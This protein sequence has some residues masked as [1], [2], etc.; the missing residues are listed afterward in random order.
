MLKGTAASPGYAIGKALVLRNEAIKI[1]KETVANVEEEKERFSSALKKSKEEIIKIREKAL[2]NLGE[3]KAAIFDAHLMILEDPELIKTI[4]Q[5][6]E[7]NYNATF[8]LK[9][10]AD[11]FIA[12]FEGM[13]NE[14][15]KERAADIRDVT[16]RILRNLT[17]QK[18]TDLSLL[19]EEVII[20]AHDLT[21]SETATMDKDKI[22]GFITNIGGRTSHTAIM[23]RTLEIPAVVGLNNATS[24]IND[25]DFIIL[26]GE[27][28]KIDINPSQDQIEEY[29]RLKD[30][31]EKERKDLEAMR[32]KASI[33]KDGRQVELGGNIGTPE[34]IN[35]LLRNDAE[36]VGLFRTE[37]LYM[38]RNTMPTEEEQFSAYKK[39]LEA[40]NPK[41]VVIRTLDIGGDKNLPYLKIDEEMNPFLGYRAI[42]LCLK[43]NKI[44]K[45]QLRAMLRASIYGNL[46]IMFPMISNLKE[47]LEAKKVLQEVMEELNQ[48]GIRFSDD[49]EVG[50]M[51]EVPSAAIISDM[52]AKHVDFFSI[53]TNDL[54]QYTCAVD[55]MNEKIHDLYQPFHPAVLRLIQMVIENG[56]KEGIWVGMCGESAGDQR[57]IPI[58][59]GMGLDEF[60]MSPISILPAR[61][62]IS[63]LSYEEWK[64]H[65]ENMLSLSTSE[66][67][68]EYV[69]R[70]KLNA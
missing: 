17:G 44:F 7:N 33:T 52:L 27:T 3:S 61:K 28:G 39:V 48:E 37:F 14:Y 56:H 24:V 59:L 36:G 46:K 64:K 47:L 49:I 35:G 6:I 23:A 8:A 12:I 26:D 1:E 40:M 65:A 10:T 4:H 55:R 42:R 30:A 58:F 67:I 57:L 66:E 63:S 45:D 41:P 62:L 69:D 38:N 21:P 5:K 19:D 53:G 11:E 18:A 70:L 25:G 51:I 54:I 29:K 2:V 13:D 15:M 16:D 20:V 31:Y 32:G 68:I 50:I 43:E 34:D 60:S 22:L 9:E